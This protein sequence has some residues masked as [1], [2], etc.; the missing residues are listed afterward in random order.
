MWEGA[1]VCAQYSGVFLA[2][3]RCD[4]RQSAVWR[5]GHYVC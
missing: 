5:P 4:V 2:T 3:E 1:T